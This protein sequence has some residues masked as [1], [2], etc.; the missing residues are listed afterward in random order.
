MINLMNILPQQPT[1]DFY[2]YSNFFYAK[3]KTGLSSLVLEL[4]GEEVFFLFSEN[5][6]KHLAGAYLQKINTWEELL[7]CLAQ[8]KNPEMKKKFKYICVDTVDSLRTMCEDYVKGYFGIEQLGDAKKSEDWMM[9]KTEWNKLQLIES[10][11]YIPVWNMHM[12][13]E[14]VKIPATEAIGVD[15]T[16]M[17]AKYSSK[18]AKDNK[19]PTHYEYEKCVPCIKEKHLNAILSKV[20]NVFFADIQEDLTTGEQKRVLYTRHT[21]Y[22]YA[23]CTLQH[24]PPVIEMSAESLKKNFTEAI[25]KQFG[26]EEVD[27]SLT[28]SVMQ[29]RDYQEAYDEVV[30][31]G[32]KM[33]EN[34]RGV[35]MTS[36]VEKYLG[37]GKSIS[38]DM[39]PEKIDK[40][41]LIILDI[42]TALNI[43]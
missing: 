38:N 8:L 11:G 16:D 25:N 22:H 26:E 19:T 43:K 12:A 5:R 27:E 24:M 15:T 29:K 14:L 6:Y 2:G 28:E 20:D 34:K 4:Y 31:L 40:L 37:E 23:G 36:I 41:E 10:M 35:E 3:P 18:E 21:M 9:L 30:S 39:S 32:R 17:K 13:T 42:K 33:F 7:L 1:K